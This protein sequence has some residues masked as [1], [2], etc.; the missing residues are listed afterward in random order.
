MKIEIELTGSPSL[1][2]NTALARWQTLAGLAGLKMPTSFMVEM[3]ELEG[4]V[5]LEIFSPGADDKLLGRIRLVTK[6]G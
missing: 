3:W 2:L 5:M 4:N 6:Q 1:P